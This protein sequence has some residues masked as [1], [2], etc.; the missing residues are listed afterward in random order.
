MIRW[1]YTQEDYP[2][3]RF[4]TQQIGLFL[5]LVT[6]AARHNWTVAAEPP[7]ATL[8][9][10]ASPVLT[11]AQIEADW[12]TQAAVRSLPK[13]PSTVT[14]A[15]T[16]S[17]AAGACDGVIDG[18]FGF[19]TQQQEQPWWQVDLGEVLPLERVVIYNRDDGV[20]QRAAQ[21]QVLLSADGQAMAGTVRSR[22]HAFLR[23]RRSE[24]VAG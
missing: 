15:T 9:T 5:A 6:V 18:H 13:Q 12:L 14:P 16:A 11:P 1:S 24:T 2:V 3:N 20:S 8:E 21:L 10:A 22:R 7:T 19:H 17:D 23:L 4:H